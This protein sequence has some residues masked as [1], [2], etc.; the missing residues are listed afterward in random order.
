MMRAWIAS[1]LYRL[2]ERVSAR[3]AGAY[4]SGGNVAA[5]TRDAVFRIEMHKVPDQS[6]IV[7]LLPDSG[8]LAFTWERSGVGWAVPVVQ[9]LSIFERS[10]YVDPFTGQYGPERPA[11]Q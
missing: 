9:L 4:R 7:S 3:Q 2:A 1:I 8:E 11:D 6:L 5:G 10:G